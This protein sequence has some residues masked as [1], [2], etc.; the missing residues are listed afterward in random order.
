ME[1]AIRPQLNRADVEAIARE[2]LGDIDVVGHEEFTDGFF[3]AAHA[4]ALADGRHLVVKVAPDPGLKLLR[5]E[6]DLMAAEIEFFERAAAAGVPMPKVWHTDAEAGLM[7]MDRLTGVS[8]AQTAEGID[9]AEKLVL[10][11]EIGELSARIVTVSGERF[12][13]PRKDGRTRS[14]S[15]AESF[16]A[17]VDDILA[18]IADRE[19]PLPRSADEIRRLVTGDRALLDEVDR[20]ALVHFDLWDGNIFV[21]RGENGWHVDGFIDGERALY[22]DPLAE[23]VSLITFI[24]PAEAAAVVDG[25]LGRALTDAEERRLCL[26]RIYLWLILIVEC[27]VR[28]YEPERTA[29]QVKWATEGLVKDLGA[30]EA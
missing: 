20:P 18:D 3:N 15:W 30:L 23:L 17:I 21:Q 24:P 16:T 12:G 5:Y 29:G 28:G 2:R 4:L 22:G 7:I 25:F 26:Y 14:G 8:L 1:I 27:D 10:R 19:A 9:E 13:Y 6:V 11:R